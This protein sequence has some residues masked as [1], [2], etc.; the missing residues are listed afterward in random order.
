MKAP[1]GPDVIK[2][3]R[4]IPVVSF[5]QVG[6][7]LMTATTAPMGHGHVYAGEDYLE[8]WLALLSPEGWDPA[9][10]DRLRAAMTARGL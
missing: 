1:R 4:W 3:L 2:E 7:D 8:G 5:L 10:L 6:F 9:A